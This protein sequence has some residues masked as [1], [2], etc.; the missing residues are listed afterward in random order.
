MLI[1]E[2][3]KSECLTILKST[4]LGRLA[5]SKDDQP[6]ITPFYFSLSG[7]CLYSFSTVGQHIEWMRANSLACVETDKVVTSHEWLSIV[8]MG[9]YEELPDTPDWQ[10]ERST[11]HELLQSK[12]DWWEPGYAKTIVHGTERP[13]VPVYFRIEIMEITGRRGLPESGGKSIDT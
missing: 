8:I 1:Q 6:Y 13:L 2:I 7:S 5:C 9:R 11:A 4:R 3:T 10:S 12:P